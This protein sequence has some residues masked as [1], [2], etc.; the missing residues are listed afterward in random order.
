MKVWEIISEVKMAWARTNP[1]ARGGAT[2]LKF[3]CT[4]GPRKSRTVSHPSQCHQPIDIAK[5]QKMKTTRAR[6]SVQQAR[7]QS[8][9]KSINTAS[10]LIKKLNQTGKGQPKPYR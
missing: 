10:S 1:T 3:R 9:T 4:T 2:K 8:R 6:T 5:A 7:R